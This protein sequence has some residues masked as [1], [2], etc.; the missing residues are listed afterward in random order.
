MGGVQEIDVEQIMDQIRENIRR[1]RTAGES[2]VPENRVSPFDDGQAAADFAQLH[3]GYDIWNVSFASNRRVVGSV[4]VAARKVLRKLLAPML[5][6]Q[7]AYNAASTRVTTHL[8]EWVGALDREQAQ[9][10]RVVNEQMET[11]ERTQ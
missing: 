11:L 6:W 1:R 8:K 7:V 10:I 5:D 2:P 9:A 3:S 4:V